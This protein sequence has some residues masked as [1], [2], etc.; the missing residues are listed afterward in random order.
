MLLDAAKGLLC[1][2]VRNAPPF[3]LP[4]TFAAGILFPAALLNAAAEL[5]K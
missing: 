1:V 5:V 2:N 3:T 4:D